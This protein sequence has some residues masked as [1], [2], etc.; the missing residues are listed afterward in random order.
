MHLRPALLRTLHAIKCPSTSL[1][2]V[3]LNSVS[4]HMRE[5][6]S[7]RRGGRHRSSP[8]IVSF[9]PKWLLQSAKLQLDD[10]YLKRAIPLGECECTGALDL[11]F[12]R[13]KQRA[14]FAAGPTVLTSDLVLA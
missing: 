13:I 12:H 1:Q 11:L 8:V 4:L 7:E 2:N 14:T 3:L 5:S 10:L 6:F 9:A